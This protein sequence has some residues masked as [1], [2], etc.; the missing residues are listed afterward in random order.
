[1]LRPIVPIVGQFLLMDG[2]ITMPYAIV[3]EV[4]YHERV[5]KDQHG[6]RQD[7]SAITFDQGK[8]LAD[9]SQ[10]YLRMFMRWVK[11]RQWYFAEHTENIEKAEGK[12][13]SDGPGKDFERLSSELT[14]LG[15]V[16]EYDEVEHVWV[17]AMHEAEELYHAQWKA[18]QS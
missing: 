16:K 17:R 2:S 18:K 10:S 8:G 11:L 15:Y 12:K 5:F 9:V 6:I 1:M 4:D 7:W 3:T 13:W 14:L